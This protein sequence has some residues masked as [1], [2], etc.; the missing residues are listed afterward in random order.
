[1]QKMQWKK[2]FF[3]LMNGTNF[4]FDCRNNSNNTKFELIIDEINEI[5]YIKKCYNPFDNKVSE[6]VNSDVLEQQI[7]QDFQQQVANVKHGDPFR[8]A[9]IK[10]IKNQNKEDVDALDCLKN[11]E[12]KSK[13]RKLTKDVDTK[14]NDVIKNKKIKTMIDFDKNECIKKLHKIDCCQRKH[15]HRYNLEI[16]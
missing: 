14:L 6:F 2:D 8:S 5:S 11:K 16:Y 10:S 15:D 3:K 9:R 13:K 7:E 4:G 1:M 12:K